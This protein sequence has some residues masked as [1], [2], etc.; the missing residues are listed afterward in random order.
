MA[1]ELK[2]RIAPVDPLIRPGLVAALA[3]TNPL[4]PL[5]EL[6]GKWV[7]KGFNQIWRPFHGAS[8]RFLELNL[9]EETLEFSENVGAIPTAAFSRR[10]LSWQ[11]STICSR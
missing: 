3:L 2:D 6:P 5:A 1:F 9:T 7:G 4:G 10:I 11:A 8:D